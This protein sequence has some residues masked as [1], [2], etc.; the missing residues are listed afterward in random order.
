MKKWNILTKTVCAV[1]DNEPTM[2]S[3]V[4]QLKE[5]ILNKYPHKFQ[6]FFVDS[7]K[8]FIHK[9]LNLSLYFSE[10][11]SNYKLFC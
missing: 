5:E 4:A 8:R 3:C 11:I 2:M 1:T 6:T 9:S 10:N 7:F